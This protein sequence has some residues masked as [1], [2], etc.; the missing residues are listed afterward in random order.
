MTPA[1]YLAVA[2]HE[3]GHFHDIHIFSSNIFGDMSSSFYDISWEDTYDMKQGQEYMDFVSGYSMTNKYEDFAEAYT[4]FLLHNTLFEKKA[5]N[6]DVLRKKY[7]FFQKHIDIPMHPDISL[8]EEIK[9]HWDSTKILY[10]Y[11]K[12]LQYY[13]SDI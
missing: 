13:K 6:S 7:D 11:E 3:F 9:Y 1:E 8:E 10:D 5:E 4:F 12:F 2:I